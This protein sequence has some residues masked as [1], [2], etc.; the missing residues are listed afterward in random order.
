MEDVSH[1]CNLSLSPSCWHTNTFTGIALYPGVYSRVSSV[2]EWIRTKVCNNSEDPPED[3]RCDERKVGSS[4]VPTSTPTLLTTSPEDSGAPQD[5]LVSIVLVLQLDENATEADF[6]LER[7]DGIVIHEAPPGSF[8]T[9]NATIRQN[10]QLQSEKEYQLVLRDSHG[11]GLF[12]SVQIYLG[13]VTVKQKIAN[14]DPY[15]IPFAYET[16]I[17]FRTS[18][19]VTLETKVYVQIRS[20]NHPQE[21]GWKIEDLDGN[22]EHETPSGAYVVAQKDYLTILTLPIDQEFVIVVSDSSG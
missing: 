19:S 21:T 12:T 22:V 3:F 10:F 15:N 14:F 8:G 5:R 7:M 18:L 13:N 11:N 9:T 17:P 4:T 20:D 16:T 2:W 6:R 1:L